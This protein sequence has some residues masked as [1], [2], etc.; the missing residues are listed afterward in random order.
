MHT[1]IYNSHNTLKIE[2]LIVSLNLVLCITYDLTADHS[3]IL[4]FTVV[5]NDETMMVRHVVLGFFSGST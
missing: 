2:L 3:F 5:I 1:T 4:H